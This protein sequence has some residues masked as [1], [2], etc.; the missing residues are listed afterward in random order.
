VTSYL[1]ILALLLGLAPAFIAHGK[2]RNFLL[3]WIYGVVLGP[4][5]LLHAIMLR[6]SRQPALDTASEAR[7]ARTDS[8]WP[9]LLR[10]ASVFAIAIIAA[11]AYRI[12]VPPESGGPGMQRE[13]VISSD[14]TPPKQTAS[15]PTTASETDIAPAPSSQMLAPA[16]EAP[17]PQPSP[18]V[19]VTVRHDRLPPGEDAAKQAAPAATTPVQRSAPAAPEPDKAAVPPPAP[20]AQLERTLPQEPS[21]TATR[22]LSPVQDVPALAARTAPAEPFDPA[23]AARK[24]ASAKASKPSSS[25]KSVPAKVAAKPSAAAPKPA[26]PEKPS[27]S[28][29]TAMGEAV[30]TVQQALAKRGYNPGPAN[31][32][33]GRQTEAAIRK[34]QA[35]RGLKQTGA[36]DYEVLEALEIVGPRVFAFEPPPGATPGR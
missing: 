17:P 16:A 20:P 32:L 8:P 29:V 24:E 15:A 13:I 4:V 26:A 9:L 14:R 36:I 28:D 30:Q 27:L 11:A 31:G 22:S 3:W 7:R 12:V 18:T 5:A 19:R 21:A 23:A 2:G 33:A 35:D 10:V 34:F 6:G 25:A 1:L